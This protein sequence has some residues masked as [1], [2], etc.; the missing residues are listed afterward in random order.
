MKKYSSGANK[1]VHTFFIDQTLSVNCIE[2][3][4][5]VSSIMTSLQISNQMSHFFIIC[6]FKREAPSLEGNTMKLETQYI[7]DNQTMDTVYLVARGEL[8]Y[9]CP[10]LGLFLD[11]KMSILIYVHLEEIMYSVLLVDPQA[12]HICPRFQGN[13][14][15]YRLGGVCM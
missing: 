6:Y 3:L 12:M 10:K 15:G 9:T 14:S 11:S 8:T 1:H 2:V 7:T 5:S 4:S 13:I